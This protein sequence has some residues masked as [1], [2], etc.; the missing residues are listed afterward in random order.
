[1]KKTNKHFLPF[2][3]ISD[4]LRKV[5]NIKD[6]HKIKSESLRQTLKEKGIEFKPIDDYGVAIYMALLSEE[7]VRLI[8][9]QDDSFIQKVYN[10]NGVVSKTN[11]IGLGAVIWRKFL[12]FIPI[13]GLVLTPIYHHKF[14]DTGIE[15]LSIGFI[16]A[17]FQ[18]VIV[19]AIVLYGI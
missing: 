4:L 13:L 17:M 8:K 3:S 10:E 19:S 9:E 6:A 15:K 11:N 12:P 5:E 1:M 14:G 16:S 18:V 2:D 7:D